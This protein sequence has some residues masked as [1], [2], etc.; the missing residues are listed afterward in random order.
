MIVVLYRRKN[1]G[2]SVTVTDRVSASAVSKLLLLSKP[3][4]DYS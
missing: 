2:R 1:N 4:T 3:G